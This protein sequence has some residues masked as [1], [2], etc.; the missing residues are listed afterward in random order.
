MSQFVYDTSKANIIYSSR[1][2]LLWESR[3]AKR[4]LFKAV[5]E[6]RNKGAT[7]GSIQDMIRDKTA[8]QIHRLLEKNQIP[9]LVNGTRESPNEIEVYKNERQTLSQKTRDKLAKVKQLQDAIEEVIQEENQVRDN[10]NQ[11]RVE[12]EKEHGQLEEKLA[13][14]DKKY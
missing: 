2:E 11:S 3:I 5:Q 1:V 6:E 8:N 13:I 12:A 9:K 4:E 10:L 7:K 14:L